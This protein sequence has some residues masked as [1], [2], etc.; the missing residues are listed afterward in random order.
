M[1]FNIA[2]IGGCTP[3]LN[4]NLFDTD[5]GQY[6]LFNGF[7][8]GSIF[9]ALPNLGQYNNSTDN[10]DNKNS[11]AGVSFGG[12]SGSFGYNPYNMHNQYFD[13]L[14]KTQEFYNNYNIKQQE[15]YRTSQAKIS[16][17]QNAIDEAASNL[18]SKIMD[19]EQDQVMEAWDAFVSAVSKAHPD[20]SGE[21]LKATALTEYYKVAKGRTIIQ[22]L[23]DYSQGSFVDGML[24]TFT[25]GLY[26]SNSAE[27]NISN[28]TGLRKGKK[29]KA[30]EAMGALTGA[31]AWGT[32]GYFTP[33][34]LKAVTP[35]LGKGG[36]WVC[37]LVALGAAGLSLL[38][39]AI[40]GSSSS[41]RS[42][43]S[44]AGSNFGSGAGT[45]YNDGNSTSST[46]NSYG[47]GGDIIYPDI[48]PSS[49]DKT[50]GELVNALLKNDKTKK[51]LQN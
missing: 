35:N 11:S 46:G 36:N 9:S 15:M 38:A 2:P 6:Q 47:G 18:R 31:A 19:N 29:E 16:A 30:K 4:T 27:D 43:T 23:K 13:Y 24:R 34:I 20:L 37:K 21:E 1:D 7:N 5:L 39:G 49:T 8:N 50:S 51:A 41:S 26:N 42:Y 25:L 22:D 28:I 45:I 33:K 14:Q 48:K 12:G 44:S 3:Y 17:P 32:I 40:F 10:K